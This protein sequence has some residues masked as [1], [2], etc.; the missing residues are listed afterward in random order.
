TGAYGTV[1][2]IKLLLEGIRK[3]IDLVTTTKAFAKI[4]AKLTTSHFPGCE[5]LSFGSDSYWECY[6]R[7]IGLPFWDSI[8]TCRMGA[9]YEDP[10]AVVD[11]RLRVLGTA[12]LRVI[13]S[14]IMPEITTTSTLSPTLMI[15]EKGAQMI[16]DYWNYHH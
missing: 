13:D 14:S 6:A 7:H 2:D 11:S 10:R 4:G 5:D 16:L 3:T 9:G 1:D 8:G 12:G 15:A